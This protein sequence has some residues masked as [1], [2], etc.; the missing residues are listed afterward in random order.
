[1]IIHVPPSGDRSGAADAA[2]IQSAIDLAHSSTPKYH[3]AGCV[4][5]SGPYIINKPICLGSVNNPTRSVLNGIG[6]ARIEPAAKFPRSQYMLSVY[7]APYGSVPVISGVSL[8][9]NDMSRGILC[10]QTETNCSLEHVYIRN[11]IESAIDLIDCWCCN[12]H[13]ID[14]L[15]FKGFA[16][17]GKNA[18]ACHIDSLFCLIA[19][20]EAHAWPAEDDTY[21]TNRYGV[22]FRTTDAERACIYW[23]GSGSTFTNLG[24]ET[25]I[26]GD[27]PLIHL[28]AGAMGN[29][30][31]SIYAEDNHINRETVLCHGGRYNRFEHVHTVNANNA[32]PQ[33]AECEC[34]L[35]CTGV[36]RGNSV[37]RLVG[38]SGIKEGGHIVLLDG[39]THIGTSCTEC[40]TNHTKVPRERWIGEVND[41]IVQA[42]WD[43]QF[44]SVD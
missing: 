44:D 40:A 4:T 11:S 16:L 3:G 19:G 31:Q 25:M 17:R 37:H 18:N 8:W 29:S 27:V 10:A 13:N 15:Y 24:L 28:P 9:C 30:F 35:R 42:E 12:L 41:P 43:D 1:M 6:D 23:H 7:G 33:V 14:V 21:C 32:N 38:W 5:L 36:T 2:A 34:F 20:R 39:G 26:Y 22:P